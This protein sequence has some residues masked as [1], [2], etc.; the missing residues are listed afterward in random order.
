[1]CDME[2]ET[3]N[4]VDL[5]YGMENKKDVEV[6]GSLVLVYVV[7]SMM[8]VI[9]SVGVLLL[10]CHHYSVNFFFG[11]VAVSSGGITGFVLGAYIYL[12][13]FERTT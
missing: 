4:G 11:I 13:M 8:A 6:V 10:L 9:G 3:L 2:I 1:M 12:L 5:I 7:A